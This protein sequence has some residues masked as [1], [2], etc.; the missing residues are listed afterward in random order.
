MDSTIILTELTDTLSNVDYQ[1]VRD[2]VNLF[3]NAHHVFCDGLGR[4]GLCCRAFAMRLMQLG[5][6]V[7]F[8][9]DTMTPAIQDG[10]LLLICSGSGSSPAL[11]SRAEK[12]KKTGAKLA[13]VTSKPNSQLAKISDSIVTIAAPAKDQSKE[14][15]SILPMGSLFEDTASLVFE[16]MVMIMMKK[17]GETSQTMLQRHANLE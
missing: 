7:F 3:L 4:S 5:I 9:G 11:I 1:D 8:V 10:D 16:N 17:L 14:I 13:L 2:M 12:A 6:D 15:Q